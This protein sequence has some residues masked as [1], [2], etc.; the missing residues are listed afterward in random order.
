MTSRWSRRVWSGTGLR[1]LGGVNL[2]LLYRTDLADGLAEQVGLVVI[3]VVGG[4]GSG[5]VK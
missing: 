1:R 3:L 2:V 4:H 5:S